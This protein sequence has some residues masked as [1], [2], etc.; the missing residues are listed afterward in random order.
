MVLYE[1]YVSRQERDAITAACDCYVSLHRSEG[2]GFTVAEAMAF[3]RPAISTGYSG[4]M[5]FTTAANSYLVD[6]SLVPIGEGAD[7]YPPEGEWAEPDLDH[8]AALMR[9]VVEQPG[10]GRGARR[11]RTA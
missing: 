2:F 7:P 11:A 10:G 9:Q 3:G 6:Y 1:R 5:D 8:A 4:T